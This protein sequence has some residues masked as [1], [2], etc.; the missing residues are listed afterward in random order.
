MTDRDPEQNNSLRDHGD[1]K[2]AQSMRWAIASI[3]ITGIAATGMF[4][5]LSGASQNPPP[6]PPGP[7]GI[8]IVYPTVRPSGLSKSELRT[9][10]TRRQNNEVAIHEDNVQTVWPTSRRI[11]CAGLADA[12][13]FNSP[14]RA[15]GRR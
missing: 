14:V 12:C 8:T 3:V 7:G 15:T 13:L 11:R 9:L 2:G 6:V 4:A 10:L 1:E 5:A